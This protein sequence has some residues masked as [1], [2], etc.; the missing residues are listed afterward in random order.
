[1]QPVSLATFRRTPVQ[2]RRFLAKSDSFT[3][4]EKGAVWQT[5]LLSLVY[6]KLLP[7]KTEARP[8]VHKVTVRIGFPN[9]CST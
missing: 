8:S 5:N 4:I 7:I 3:L 9:S 1:M 2:W 6:P